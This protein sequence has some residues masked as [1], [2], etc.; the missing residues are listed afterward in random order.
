MLDIDSINSVGSLLYL[1]CLVISCDGEG[2]SSVQCQCTSE[3]GALLY[4][5]ILDTGQIPFNQFKS[6]NYIFFSA[7]RDAFI[8]RIR[9]LSFI[10]HQVVLTTDKD[11]AL[12]R[13][14]EI[15]IDVLSNVNISTNSN[16]ADLD[17][18]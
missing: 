4:S 11:A 17:F 18:P 10:H 16:I 15:E 14:G 6:R 1:Q 13:E 9:L 12:I 2:W 3:G 8:F 7:A 5:A